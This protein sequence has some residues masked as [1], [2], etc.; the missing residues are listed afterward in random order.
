M[1]T[2]SKKSKQQLIIIVAVIMGAAIM[3]LQGCE[4]VLNKIADK[5]IE[6]LEK[7]YSPSPY[8]PGLDPDRVDVNAFARPQQQQMPPGQQPRP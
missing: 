3:G 1:T 7:E 5:V 2:K 8:G 4:M 6:K